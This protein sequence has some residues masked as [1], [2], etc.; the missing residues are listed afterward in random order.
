MFSIK[1]GAAV[2]LLLQALTSASAFFPPPK[3]SPSI[4]TSDLSKSGLGGFDLIA[5]TN[6]KFIEI[7][8]PTTKGGVVVSKKAAIKKV[9]ASPPPKKVTV[10]KSGLTASKPAVTKNVGKGSKT[11]NNE[12][13]TP[14]FKKLF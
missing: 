3:N 11:S 14:W 13:A 10:A 6:K 5:K 1:C 2:V 7:S 12:D 9:V 4:K 8:A